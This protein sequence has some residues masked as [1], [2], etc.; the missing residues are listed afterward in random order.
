MLTAL[1][2]DDKIFA[3][4]CCGAAGYVLKDDDEG[5]P[6]NIR[7]VYEEKGNAFYSQSIAYK[8]QKLIQSKLMRKNPKYVEF[9][10]L[11]IKVLQG[12]VDGKSRPNIA[13]WITKNGYNIN[14]DAVSDH[15]KNIFRKFQV[16][17]ATSAVRE[18]ILGGY[19]VLI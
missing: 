6:E 3:A 2:D 18:A 19:V 5:L 10:D 13:D 1:L 11:E 9:T 12:L 15:I 4:I 7:C 16:N 17:S 14:L 8:A